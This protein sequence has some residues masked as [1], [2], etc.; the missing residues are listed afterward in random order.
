MFQKKGFFLVL[1]SNNRQNRQVIKRGYNMERITT[2]I[3]EIRVPGVVAE[4]SRAEAI[5]QGIFEE[6]AVSLLEAMVANIDL[7]GEVEDGNDR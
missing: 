3:D 4:V 6:N 2:N 1:E 7:V 5:Q